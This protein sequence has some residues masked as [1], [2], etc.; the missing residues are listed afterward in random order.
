[1]YEGVR[2]GV[3]DVHRDSKR[4]RRIE[5]EAKRV[6][7]VVRHSIAALHRFETEQ[8]LGFPD[9]SK[10]EHGERDNEPS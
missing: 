8:R 5:T 4:E 2:T 3:E 9:T 6:D 10:I 7:D 1:M